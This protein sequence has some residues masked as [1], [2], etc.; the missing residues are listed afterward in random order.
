MRWG[1]LD[2]KAAAIRAWV[3]GEFQE[4][5]SGGQE[6]W[7]LCREEAADSS[8]LL[9]FTVTNGPTMCLFINFPGN[10]ARVAR[11]NVH[12]TGAKHMA[13]VASGLNRNSEV[14]VAAVTRW[15][16]CTQNMAFVCDS[17]VAYLFQERRKAHL[18]TLPH[19]K[20]QSNDN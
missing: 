17:P 7:H 4:A 20:D 18:K 19:R 6:G 16:K 3:P 8:N 12:A 13:A 14:C 11:L 5:D 2:K 15:Q 9:Y 1:T 10:S